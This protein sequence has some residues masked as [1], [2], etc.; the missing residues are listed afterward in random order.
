M[1]VYVPD[2]RP[3]AERIQDPDVQ[4]WVDGRELSDEAADRIRRALARWRRQQRSE[5]AS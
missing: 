5:G 2:T 1:A 4:A 3:M